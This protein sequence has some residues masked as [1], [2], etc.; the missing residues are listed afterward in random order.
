MKNWIPLL[1]GAI[2]TTPYAIANVDLGEYATLSGFGSTSWAQSDNS[3]PL[4]IHR[5]IED[6]S[7]FDCDTTFGLQLDL[8]YDNIRAS[9]QLVKRPQDNWSDPELEWVYLA[10]NLENWTFQIGRLRAPLFLYS[11]YYYVGQAYTPSR[12][13][14]EVYSSILGITYYEGGSITWTQDLG[15]EYTLSI[16]PF[17][18]IKDSKDIR[19]SDSTFLELETDDMYG[20]NIV[21]SSNNYRWNFSYLNSEYDQKVTLFNHMVDTPSGPIILPSV[22]EVEKDIGIELFSIGAEYEF[23]NLTFTTEAQKSDRT[24]SWYAMVANR[25]GQWTPYLSFAQQYDENDKLEADSL[26]LGARYDIFYN[27]SINAEWQY[28]NNKQPLVNGAFVEEPEDKHA[29]LFTVMLNFVF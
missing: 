26:L 11:E 2:F 15:E 18:G 20:L 14:T 19:L 13:P 6:S 1:L 7:C 10:Y 5:E 12:P 23:D 25:Y 4:L 9:A 27:V 21:F 22:V 8:Y 17:A 3:M 29:N 28:F 24:T 16:T